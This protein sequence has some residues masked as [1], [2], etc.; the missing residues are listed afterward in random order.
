MTVVPYTLTAVVSSIVYVAVSQTLTIAYV[1]TLKDQA[2]G[3]VSQTPKSLA[4]T[5]ADFPA[6]VFATIVAQLNTV[7]TAFLTRYA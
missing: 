1:E 6:G 4:L 5:A 2:G 3:T 7:A